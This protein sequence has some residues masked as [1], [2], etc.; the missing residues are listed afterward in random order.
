LVVTK[1]L[2]NLHPSDQPPLLAAV[3]VIRF[4]KA[5]AQTV[6]LQVRNGHFVCTEI[7]R[8]G[9]GSFGGGALNP[10]DINAIDEWYDYKGQ[11][12]AVDYRIEVSEVQTPPGHLEIPGPGSSGYHSLWSRTLHVSI[13]GKQFR[14]LPATVVNVPAGTDD[15]ECVALISAN[16]EV[17]EL[18]L[19][20][21]GLTDA[22]MALVGRLHH[23]R[24]L[25]LYGTHTTDAG[26]AQLQTM[27][28]L[29]TL[30]L[31]GTKVTDAGVLGLDRLTELEK[32]G[33][34]NTSITDR[35][36]AIVSRFPHLEQL[37]LWNTRIGD[38]TVARLSDLKQLEWLDLRGTRVTDEGAQN[39]TNLVHLH[40]LRL[41]A[42]V[43]DNGLEVLSRA[44]PN[45]SVLLQ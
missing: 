14:E 38:A 45:C 34:G 2:T 28:R 22:A 41:P 32:L 17:E 36:A 21:T 5:D 11:D 31:D 8:Q 39:L 1:E 29:R 44:L 10:D 20:N 42:T 18:N 19:E 43:T 35:G 15:S 26:L 9:R 27:T 24:V 16:P 23:L 30:N 40:D 7:D 4:H 25:F 12:L 37:D 6:R 33:L 3:P 13:T